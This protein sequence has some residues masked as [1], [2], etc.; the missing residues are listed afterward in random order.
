MPCGANSITSRMAASEIP[1]RCFVSWRVSQDGKEDI[2]PKPFW[3]CF[4]PRTVDK[5]RLRVLPPVDKGDPHYLFLLLPTLHAKTD[6]EY[7]TVRRY[8][9]E[10]CCAVAKL[11]YPEANDIVGIATEPGVNNG[12]RSEDA[13]YFDARGWNEAMAGNA[14]ELQ[15]KLGILRQ[16]QQIKEY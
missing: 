6:D 7:R 5:R 10:S 2:W 13:I 16:P 3:I 14:R 15:E 4:V 9:L 11:E 1:R 12:G 8:F